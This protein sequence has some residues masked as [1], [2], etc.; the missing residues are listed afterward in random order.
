M[1]NA[2]RAGWFSAYGAGMPK[3]VFRASLFLASTA[4]ALGGCVQTGAVVERPEWREP[5][6]IYGEYLA[7]R[8]ADLSRDP[9]RASDRY[10]NALRAAPDDG[11]LLDGAVESALSAGEVAR[12]VEAARLGGERGR[13]TPLGRLALA[14]LELAADRPG[15]ARAALGSINGPPFD[16]LAARIVLAWA[17]AGDGK[18]D[19]AI[20]GLEP[21]SESAPF[22]RLFDYQRALLLDFAGRGEAALAGYERARQGGLRLAPAALAHGRL[23]QRLGRPKEAGA[24]YRSILEGGPDPFIAAALASLE[25]GGAAPAPL[26]RPAHGAAIGLFSL[27]GVL[28]GQMEPDF[29]LPY[30]TLAFTLDPDLAPARLLYAEGL[31]EINQ[32]DAARAALAPVP[33][34]SPGFE[35][36][37]VQAAWILRQQ[38]QN[39]AAVQKARAVAAA[40]NGKLSRL[41]LAD[42]LRSLERWQEAEAA[43]HSLLTDADAEAASDWRLYFARGA[44]R[45]RLGRWAEAEAD[46][47]RALELSPDQPDVLNYLGYSWIEKGMKLTEG[48]ALIERAVALSPE[49]GY[50]VDSLG[51]AHFMLGQYDEAVEH[52][53]RAVELAPEDPTLNDHLGDAYWRVRR[54][55]EARYQW[56]RALSFD[57]P[58]KDR[59][60]IEAKLARGLPEPPAPRTART[61]PR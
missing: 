5:S 26:Q 40:T 60:A 34:S 51:W 47:Q 32:L 31:R 21:G 61:A 17:L 43:Y 27:A 24:L 18:V 29:Y 3:S 19:E 30:L 16:R 9:A 12:A 20:A 52:L 33:A 37:E 44:A 46:L 36:A 54:R 53:E 10:L 48:L 50:I 14:S 25:Q 23:L 42:I 22:L 2:L 55:V 45:E 15:A 59:P 13:D 56:S 49:S 35:M 39:E 4:L 57:P 8:Y 58:A 7:G 28:I 38:E 6:T 41:A 1:A 11:V